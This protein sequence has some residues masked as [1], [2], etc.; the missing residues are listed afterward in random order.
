VYRFHDNT[1]KAFRELLAATGLTHPEQLGPEHVIRRVSSN[2][3]RSLAALYHW[4]ESGALI[5]GTSD[6]AVFKVFWQ[7]A[8]PESFNVPPSVLSLRTSKQR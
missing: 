7:Q 5:N 2:E 3:V 4:V 6:H 8:N 1:L